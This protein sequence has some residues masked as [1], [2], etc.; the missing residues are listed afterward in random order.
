MTLEV[1]RFHVDRDIMAVM[2]RKKQNVLF[3]P[4]LIGYLAY[5]AI[6]YLSS[7]NLEFYLLQFSSKYCKYCIINYDLRH[8]FHQLD[9]WFYAQVMLYV[10]FTLES[11]LAGN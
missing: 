1:K 5:H 7:L 10:Y 8:V 4:L 6:F 2:I 9:V 3:L 11:T